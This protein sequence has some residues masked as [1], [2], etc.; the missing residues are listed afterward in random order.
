MGMASREKDKQRLRQDGMGE[1]HKG[2]ESG[3]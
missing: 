2:D 1:I 3:R